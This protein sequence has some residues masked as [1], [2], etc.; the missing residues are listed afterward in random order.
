MLLAIVQ[1]LSLNPV[2]PRASPIA[3][4]IVLAKIISASSYRRKV[5]GRIPMTKDTVGWRP[6][7]LVLPN[8]IRIDIHD[9][10]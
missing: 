3:F 9:M 2:A 7:L 4:P 6:G 1:S 5:P 8:S 10:G